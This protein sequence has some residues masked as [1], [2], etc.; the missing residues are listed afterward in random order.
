MFSHCYALANV[1]GLSALEFVGAD[2]RVVDSGA[3]TDTVSGLRGLS[4]EVSEADAALVAAGN[5]VRLVV[6]DPAGDAVREQGG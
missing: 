4:V 1:D 3:T 5:D 6:L 2:V